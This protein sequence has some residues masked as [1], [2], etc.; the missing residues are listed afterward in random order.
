[1][2]DTK[3]SAL[4]AL[5]AGGVATDDLLVIVDT[6]ATETKKY[7][8]SALLTD[9]ASATQTLT[10]KTISLG[11]NTLSGT[12]AQ[13]NTALSDDNFVT[14][15][16]TETL[17]N[18]T[19]TSP[20]VTGALT[21]DSDAILVRHGANNLA[22]RNSTNA[23]IFTVFN[24]YTDGS[25]FERLTLGWDTNIAYVETGNAGSGSQRVLN[26]GGSAINFRIGGAAK[27][28]ISTGGHLLFNTDN[29]NDIGA[30]GATRPRTGY[31]GTSVIT[32][33]LDSPSATNLTLKAGGNTIATLN[34]SSGNFD[35]SGGGFSVSRGTVTT[36]VTHFDFSITW[37]SAGTTFDGA[38][39]IFTETASGASSRYFQIKGG[40]AGTTDEFY[41]LKGGTA[42]VNTSIELGHATDTTITRSAAGKIAV[43]GVDVLTV[44][45]GT[46]T[47][48]ITLGE[49]TSI[50]LDPAGS[51]DGK[52]SGICI[53][54]TAGTTLAFG[55]LIYLAAADSR[56]ELADADAAST[57]ARLLGIC[58]LAAAADGD[59]TKI[60]LHG[61]IRADAAF[62]ALTIGSPAYVGETAGDIQTAI[63][64]G[65]DNV[66][67]VVGYALTADE[68]YFC[69]SP[70]H[71][72]TVA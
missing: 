37:N 64:T 23:Q 68:L 47:G 9:L 16:G 14:L 18:K 54:G 7:A 31:F 5:A 27:M 39:W 22:M 58:V 41:I 19:L 48:N 1:M 57:S 50:D 67:R 59:P 15:T 70:D 63:P 21:I 38:K 26:V 32:P 44:A 56:W 61:N 62:P 40:A 10:N 3:I 29:T 28:N 24:T 6:S 66:I 65:A 69:P 11:S 45:G 51:A 42:Y 72:V 49:N 2:A 30:S 33:L 17:T 43:E 71:Q 53:T 35:V 12:V 46:L 25:N 52:Y 4:T 20:A 8:W 13:F 34:A 60:L 55:D 36:G